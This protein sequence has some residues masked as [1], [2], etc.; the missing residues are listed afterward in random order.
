MFWLFILLFGK[1]MPMEWRV[2]NG[3][4]CLRRAGSTWAEPLYFD[5]LPSYMQLSVSVTF[6]HTYLRVPL[7]LC[8]HSLWTTISPSTSLWYISR[9]WEHFDPSLGCRM[10]SPIW[11]FFPDIL[12]YAKWCFHRLCV[13]S[14]CGT[15]G[16]YFALNIW[17]PSSWKVWER[18]ANWVLTGFT[19]SLCIWLEYIVRVP[20][21]KLVSNPPN[22]DRNGV[23][24]LCTHHKV[25]CATLRFFLPLF[26]VQFPSKDLEISQDDW[27]FICQ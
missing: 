15:I 19:F 11:R 24:Y 23:W 7:I 25:F 13:I 3:V 9:W 8:S 4:V 22:E 18:S 16:A 20:A 5:N 17:T 14:L 26:G 1:A 21:V 2:V 27:S 12:F 6:L 10:K